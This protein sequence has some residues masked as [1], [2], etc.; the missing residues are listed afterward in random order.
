MISA[1]RIIRYINLMILFLLITPYY[2][3]AQGIF[4]E[5]LGVEQGLGSSK[6]Y[7][8]IQDSRY[9]IWLGTES[10][11]SRFDGNR[12]EN[13]G[14]AQGLAAGGIRSI[15]Q[16]TT[17]RVWFG[18]LN[19]GVSYYDG[20]KFHRSKFN[21]VN[22][23]SDIT[24]I[25][26]EGPW[27]WFTTS[28]NGAF[29]IKFPAPKDTLLEGKHYTGRD[30]LSDQVFGLYIDRKNNLFCITDAFIKKYIAVQDTFETYSPK[31]LTT[32]FN[33]VAM[34]QDTK[35]NY[36][37]GLHNGGLYRQDA[38][39]GEMKI[40]DILNGLSRM[41][42]TCFA[43]DYR[44]NVW[45]GT[46]GG[47]ITVFSGDKTTIYNKNNGLN[48]LNIHC[49][50]EDSEKNMLIADHYEGFS[51]FKGDYFVTYNTPEF[52][53]DNNVWAISRDENGRYWFG[54]NNGISV[55]H[56]YRQEKPVIYN[57]KTATIGNNIRFITQ[58]SHGIMW[59][60][61]QGYGIYR[62]DP[63][64]GR[65]FV[66]TGI[67]GMLPRDRTVT[68]MGTDRNGNLWIGS[69]DG[70]AKWDPATS[71][72]FVYTQSAGLA[73]NVITAL[74][75]DSR[76]TVWVGSEMRS[77]LSKLIPTETKFT[78][79]DIGEGIIPQTIGETTDG[80]IW[81][82]TVNGLIAMKNDV[83]DTILTEN[84]GLLS[85]NIKFL[86]PD[87]DRYLYIGTN[88]GLN[89][90]D[91]NNGTIA[92]FTRYSGFTGIEALKN[93]AYRDPDGKLWFGT[94][95]GVTMLDPEKIPPAIEPPRIFISGMDVNYIPREM[96]AGLKLNY[97]EK[98]VTFYYYS[99]SLFDPSSVKYR[100]MMKGADPD[101]RP[102]T[103]QTTAF[104][105]GLPPGHYTFMVKAV[106]S[107]GNWSESPVEYSFIIKPP[108]YLS[109]WFIITMTIVII[110]SI[111]IYIKIRERNLV[112]EKRILEAKVAE[113]T[114]ELVLKNQIIEEKNRDITAS[115]RYAE[116]IQRA[117]LPKEDDFEETF[118][119]FLPKDIVSGDFYWMYDNGDVRLIA[120]VDC[121]GHGVPGAFMSII[122]HNSLNKVVREYGL[123]RPS[124]I[125]DQLNI[126][127]NK[128]IIQSQEKGITDGMD[129]A[130]IA[131]N[132]KKFTLEY[133]GAYNPL[134]VVRNGEVITF[135]G[136]RFPIGMIS[137]EQKKNF[138]N[139]SVEIKPGDMV[140]MCSDGYA[141]QFGTPE[142][143]K[144][145]VGNI[146]RVLAE[147]YHLPV[148][149]QKMRLEKEY[150]DWKGDL[151]QVD[152]I[153]FIGMR[154]I[155]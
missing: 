106:N 60:G 77:G 148:N 53:S 14:S 94:A 121:T 154:I 40:F 79:L 47:G 62:Y 66:D 100:V 4:F 98:S 6:V 21:E 146:K 73:G 56:P 80:T 96:K 52:L 67:N 41:F 84:E 9:F 122:G 44:G 58:G 151:P 102:V 123:I 17:G 90:L 155:P 138:T 120:A 61:T 55:F 104:N 115:I 119:L 85:N 65:F 25:R 108:F 42:V 149:E 28:A 8:I 39:T 92:S 130:I 57:D 59:V 99:V 30:G 3:T 31:G 91:L 78:I 49:I 93:A 20:Q 22:V 132:R 133:A 107:S 86:C 118:V 2:L 24:G 142:G 117:M 147:I 127:V 11:V 35:G 5:K 38:V 150:L 16:D 114:A 26:Q 139:V 135:K 89:R 54:T 68:A 124:A 112:R 143:K 12:F 36:W 64:K 81:I 153:L 50:F 83:V 101:W 140:Y 134:Y 27:L 128:S 43:E 69:N 33:V 7:S 70:L 109:P 152:D 97:R 136:D 103:D 141:D 19:G 72:G 29:R 87:N 113:R 111:I 88:R 131:Y 1:C 105:S 63:K 145:K 137:I 129:L 13:F 126:E 51:I 75:C 10:G 82:G 37:Y 125:L 23:N 71:E 48:A 32:Y 110:C 15:F 74:F 76:G 18:H 45:V 46:W 95:N 144:F 116:R 34:Y